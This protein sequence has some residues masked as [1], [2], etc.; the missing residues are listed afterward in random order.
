MYRHPRSNWKKATGGVG[1]PM[2]AKGRKKKSPQV[3]PPTYRFHRESLEV[4]S[5]KQHTQHD[6]HL[7]NRN[8][9]SLAGEK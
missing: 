5:L 6:V 7:A 3:G 2:G 9:L 8:T 4:L 1:R